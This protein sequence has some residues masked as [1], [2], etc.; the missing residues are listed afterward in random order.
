VHQQM[1]PR[2]SGILRQFDYNRITD[3]IM[4]VRYTALDRGNTLRQAASVGVT[5]FIKNITGI[6]IALFDLPHKFAS[7]WY[8]A[9]C[10]FGVLPVG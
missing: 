6:S 4:Q 5:D 9:C 8:K 3:V 2:A 7:E 1:A 10:G